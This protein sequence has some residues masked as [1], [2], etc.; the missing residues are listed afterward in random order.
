MPISAKVKGRK[1]LQRTSLLKITEVSCNFL[2][3]YESRGYK[4]HKVSLNLLLAVINTNAI[5]IRIRFILMSQKGN[6]FT[7]LGGMTEN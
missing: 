7:A 4:L 3:L 6:Y 5:L 1:E 2:E